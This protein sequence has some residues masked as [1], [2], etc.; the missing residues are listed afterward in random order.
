MVKRTLIIAAFLLSLFPALSSAQYR[1]TKFK[2]ISTVFRAGELIPQE[3]TCEGRNIHPPLLFE[4][5]PEKTISLAL[6]MEDPDV[7]QGVFVHWILYNMP[8]KRTIPPNKDPGKPGKTDASEKGIYSGPCPH[9]GVHHYH[10]KAYA[11]NTMLAFKHPPAKEELEVAMEGHIV[12]KA[13][14][15]GT[16]SKQQQ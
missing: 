7:P 4:H 12:D 11:L 16:Y 3:Y 5:I 14:L 6:I 9:S 8:P 15:I 13:E 10:F 2:L 1:V